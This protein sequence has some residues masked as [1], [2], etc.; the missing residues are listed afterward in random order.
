MALAGILETTV[1]E[2]FGAPAETEP[3]SARL[4]A[5]STPQHATAARRVTLSEIAG[6]VVA[7]PLIG[8]RSLVPGFV[9]ALGIA[10]TTAVIAPPLNGPGRRDATGP[11]SID[12]VRVAR[13][14]PTLAIA[15]CDP[16][17]S[18]LQGPLQRHDPPVGLAWWP[19]GNNI[20]TE[21]LDSGAAHAVALHRSLGGRGR[22]RSG[23][24]VVGFARWREGLAVSPAFAGRVKSIADV[25]KLDLRIANREVG[26]EARSILDE[27]LKRHGIAPEAIRGYGTTCNAH[28]LVASAISSGLADVGVTTEPAAL[29][30]GL[31]FLAWQDEICELHIPRS[32]MGSVEVRSLLDVLGGRELPA[33]LAA[34]EGYDAEPCGRI[35]AA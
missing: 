12:A 4:G 29:A 8:D 30:Y 11:T 23:V 7:F 28:L 34:L 2:L 22:H 5:R 17:L 1:E 18:L 32:L 21:L 33:Q 25:A 6:D 19:C 31:G 16:A 13:A 27:Q 24:E 10:E 26:S 20:A 9:P 3:V 14:S 15:G 35:L